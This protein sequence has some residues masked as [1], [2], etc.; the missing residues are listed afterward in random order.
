[1]EHTGN[2]AH[3][4]MYIERRTNYAYLQ[5]RIKLERLQLM[6]VYITLGRGKGAP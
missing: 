3:T 6:D 5:C 2:T 1:M 4:Y